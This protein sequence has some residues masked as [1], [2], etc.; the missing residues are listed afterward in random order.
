MVYSIPPTSR[1]IVSIPTWMP[2]HSLNLIVHTQS[3]QIENNIITLTAGP[4][5]IQRKPRRETEKT[6]GRSGAQIKPTPS[7]QSKEMEKHRKVIE[8]GDPLAPSLKRNKDTLKILERHGMSGESKKS[9]GSIAVDGIYDPLGIRR[10]PKEELCR[11]PGPKN[12]VGCRHKS[13]GKIAKPLPDR[14]MRQ[15]SWTNLKD[16][17]PVEPLKEITIDSISSKP[18][19]YIKKLRQNKKKMPFLKDPMKQVNAMVTPNRETK[20]LE[21]QRRLHDSLETR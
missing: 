12:V 14:A 3:K 16:A 10:R 7:Q 5:N 8:R 18:R 21:M 2:S 1:M 13:K 6:S 17:R 4:I 9:K 20:Y 11:S 15:S 19:E